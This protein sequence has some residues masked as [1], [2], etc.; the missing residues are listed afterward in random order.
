MQNFKKFLF[1]NIQ[2]NK[3][4]KEQSDIIIDEVKKRLSNMIQNINPQDMSDLKEIYME[5]FNVIQNDP[6]NIRSYNK[7]YTKKINY[8]LYNTDMLKEY[9]ETSSEPNFIT[10]FLVDNIFDYDINIDDEHKAIDRKIYLELLTKDLDS[11]VR[12]MAKNINASYGSYYISGKITLYV[13]IILIF[14]LFDNS[15]NLNAHYTD[16]EN[17][18]SHE[19]THVLDFQRI[20]NKKNKKGIKPKYKKYGMGP[21]VSGKDRDYYLQQLEINAYYTETLL[22][23]QQE[24]ENNHL[25]IN[26]KNEIIRYFK[27]NYPEY[28]NY[29]KDITKRLM[30][31][32]YKDIWSD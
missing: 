23:I 13:S 6:K 3:I 15:P 1:E 10:R 25:D 19:L 8:L 30:N 5:Y 12:G 26:N 16:L 9:D 28:D 24:I 18:V 4:I 20:P 31:R 21:N 17:T 27:S 2:S 7:E 29:P 32:L 22:D 11:N 14:E